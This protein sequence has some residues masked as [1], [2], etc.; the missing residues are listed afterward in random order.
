MFDN[1]EIV[2]PSI[3][4][5][6]EFYVSA[7]GRTRGVSMN[8][9]ARLCGAARATV[10]TI[11]NTIDKYN[12]GAATDL[13]E[14]LEGFTGEAFYQPLKG[15]NGAKIVPSDTAAKIVRY[16]AYDAK[17]VQERTRQTAQH[18]YHKFAE[19]GMDAWI[20]EIVNYDK[21]QNG[22]FISQESF[23]ELIGEMRSM[24]QEM[25][26]LREENREWQHIRKQTTTNWKGMDEMLDKVAEEKSVGIT[27]FLPAA[28]DENDYY[29]LTEWLETKGIKLDKSNTHR[30]ALLVSETF[31]TM[32]YKNPTRK[33]PKGFTSGGKVNI[34]YPNEFPLLEI[35]L[36]KL[37][38]N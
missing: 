37:F 1:I 33:L 36:K 8:G 17:K 3:I 4:D 25:N 27:G 38:L 35:A 2:S 19:I 5:G 26:S 31:K 11:L 23:L 24:R 7:D 12:S 18:S 9:L 13:P 16:F 29:T 15:K 30:L 10:Y 34:Y 20:D 22:A 6:I 14:W 21:K 28:K 32:A